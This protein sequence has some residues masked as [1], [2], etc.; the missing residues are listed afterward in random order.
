MSKRE[1]T[2]DNL[3]IYGAYSQIAEFLQ[4]YNGIQA[5]Y[6]T[7]ASSWL[8]AT[9]IGIGYSLSSKEIGLPFHPL[10]TVAFICLAS[11]TGVILIWYMDLIVCEQSI[12]AVV[13]EGI[14]LEKKNAWLPRYYHNINRI[15]SLLSYV[16]LKSF[17]YLGCIAILFI[18]IAVALTIYAILMGYTHVV[19]IPV[20]SV[21]FVCLISYALISTMKKTDPY[22]RLEILKRKKLV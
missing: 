3:L 20:I 15:G 10:V 22:H 6:R 17:F 14:E 7:F 4:H 16:N 19:F 9:F 11:T 8:L 2:E 12:A 21:F 1:P 5:T 18:T 13:Y